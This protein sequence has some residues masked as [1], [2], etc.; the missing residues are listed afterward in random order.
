MKA[1][2]LILLGFVSLYA[3]SFDS[4]L[5][6]CLQDKFGTFEKF[7]Y[8]IIQ[9]PKGY[10][11]MEINSEKGFRLV[12]NYAYIP[13]KIYDKQNIV[14]NSLVT[15][16]VKLYKTVL[17]SLRNINQNEILS[18]AKFNQKL[19]DVA[20]YAD[21]IVKEE[22]LVNKRSK[23]LVKSGA[24]LINEMIEEIPAVNKGDKVVVHAGKEAVDISVDA[25]SR[26]DGCVGEVISVQ[27]NN[28]IFKAK[29]VDKFNL[30]LVE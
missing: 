18:A 22:N 6:S 9:A 11:K 19:E 14:S 16:R 30:T 2:F 24:I 4:Q 17:V 12:K 20:A 5:K 21:K 15:I 10:S 8:Q 27:A 26:Q 3:D 25:I 28:K 29:V 23:V 7:E 1:L 13:V